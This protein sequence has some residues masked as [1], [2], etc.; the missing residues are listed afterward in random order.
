MLCQ[1][2]CKSMLE[3]IARY[4]DQLNAAHDKEPVGALE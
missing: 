1:N 2:N 3:L 4:R